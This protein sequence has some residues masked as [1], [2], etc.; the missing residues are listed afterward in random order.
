MIKQ[1]IKKIHKKIKAYLRQFRLFLGR[2][3]L[4]KKPTK[5]WNQNNLPNCK[6]LFIRHDGKIGDFIVSSFIYREIKK[7]YPNIQIG[8]VVSAETEYLFRNDPYIDSIYVT[9]KRALIPFW[10]V[11]CQVEKEQYDVVI[12]LTEALRN[13]DIIL[14][15]CV[16]A[17]INIG[18][19]QRHLKLFNYN[20]DACNEHITY[21]YEKALMSLGLTKMDRFCSFPNIPVTNE[22]S[23]FRQKCLTQNYIAINF[24]GAANHKKFSLQRQLEWLVKLKKAYPDTTILILTYPKVTQELKSSLP[25]D[26][27]VMYDN[28]QTIFDTIELVRHA[29]M[30]ISPDTSIIHIASAFNKPIIA[31]YMTANPLNPYRKWMPLNDENTSIYYYK[32]NINEID[33][34]SIIL[35]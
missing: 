10:Q 29:S 22:L 35:N 24:F 20:I 12:D 14:I 21:D 11:G 17:A 16:N 30:V 25:T 18:Y 9:R 28:T 31:F 4:D 19:N 6:I 7:Q 8:V 23:E 33:L 27:F 32:N 26:Q 1:K 34:A 13:R 2:L 15:R 5:T 3:V